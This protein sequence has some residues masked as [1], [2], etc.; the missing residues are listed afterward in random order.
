MNSQSPP[1]PPPPPP[2][3]QTPALYLRANHDYTSPDPPQT[4][5]FRA[6]DHLLLLGLHPSGWADGATSDRRQ[7][8]WFPSNY[9]Q[10]GAAAAAAAAARDRDL[11]AWGARASVGA[12]VFSGITV[13]KLL[14]VAVL[15]FTRSRI[16]E[17]YYFRV[18]VALVGFAA[19]YSLIFLPVALSL[20]GGQ[21]KILLRRLITRHLTT[22][23]GYVDHEAEGGLERDLRS[24]RYLLADD[25]YD[26]DEY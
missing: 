12:S 20:F 1:P 19:S 18:W 17:I 25:E 4:F 5:D 26:S 21:G 23:A 22:G 7:R 6:G 9:C 10:S 24:R 11:R 15:A 14:G 16:F 2:S 13:T 3:R 8:G